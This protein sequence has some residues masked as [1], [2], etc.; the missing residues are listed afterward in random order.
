MFASERVTWNIWDCYE[1]KR[2][3]RVVNNGEEY[4]VTAII[5]D[6]QKHMLTLVTDRADL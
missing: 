2:G 3:W 5:P 6:E 4:T 1:I